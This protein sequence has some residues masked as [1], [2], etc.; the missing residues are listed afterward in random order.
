MTEC[1]ISHNDVLD[2]WA[3]GEPAAFSA[4]AFDCS[5]SGIYRIAKM[6][7]RAKDPRG[8]KPAQKVREQY[9]A[10]KHAF[11]AGN[12]ARAGIDTATIAAKLGIEVRVARA[13]IYLA[14]QQGQDTGLTLGGDVST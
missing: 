14:T 1:R 13:A 4:G 3:S 5:V 2:A 8:D 12:M 11:K 7:R 9:L 6:A 10:G